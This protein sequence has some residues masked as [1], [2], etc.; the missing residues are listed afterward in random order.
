MKDDLSLALMGS[1]VAAPLTSSPTGEKR[2]DAAQLLVR[3][4]I[5][6]PAVFK[7]RAYEAARNSLSGPGGLI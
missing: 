3:T 2:S 4:T 5:S 7:A 1:A 6:A